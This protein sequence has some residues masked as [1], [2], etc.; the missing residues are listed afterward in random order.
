[1]KYKAAVVSI[2]FQSLLSH[3][4]YSLVSTYLNLPPIMSQPLTR[5]L[6]ELSETLSRRSSAVEASACEA[7]NKVV[8]SS[9]S[10]QFSC[11]IS[12]SSILLFSRTTRNPSTWLS[13]TLLHARGS[14]SLPL[15]ALIPRI[16]NPSTRPLLVIPFSN[17][18]SQSNWPLALCV[19]S[20]LSRAPFG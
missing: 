14:E 5:P 20:G 18:K 13:L 2:F 6:H 19:T 8:R 7:F 15:T 16:L 10:F 9:T 3:T 1:M 17:D 12:R 4:Q 11:V